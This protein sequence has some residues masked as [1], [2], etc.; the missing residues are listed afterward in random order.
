MNDCD[1]KTLLTAVKSGDLGVDE[2][3]ARFREA[4]PD[5]PLHHGGSFTS[6]VVTVIE[7]HLDDMNPELLGFL[8][9]R[10]QEEGAL[11]VA[12]SPLQMK[13]NRPAVKL[14]VI[15]PPH[16]LQSLSR[17][18][19]LESTAIGV[20]FY[21][22]E[23]LKLERVAETRETSLGTVSVKVLREGG[24]TVRITPEFEEC[25][26]VAR[27]TGLPLPE[28]YRIIERETGSLR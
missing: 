25:C 1:L 19:L 26:R 8:M 23:R 11:D 2:A 10:L 16:L 6:D 4:I 27:E 17:L 12:F 3:A 28:V 21:Q 20:R 22:A 9:E 7:T 15:T 13:K 14:T 5:T 18:V 24:S